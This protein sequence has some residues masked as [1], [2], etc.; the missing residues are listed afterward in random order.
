MLTDWKLHM[1]I[2]WHLDGLDNLFDGEYSF[3]QSIKHIDME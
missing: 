3:G 1:W 2:E